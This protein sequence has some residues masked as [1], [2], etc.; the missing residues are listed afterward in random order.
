MLPTLTENSGALFWY[1]I[2]L[3]DG[4]SK[5]RQR[6]A[7]WHLKKART[8]INR[9]SFFLDRAYDVRFDVFYK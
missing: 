3:F 5:W 6:R 8:N 2:A 9:V 7:K 1:T 4:L